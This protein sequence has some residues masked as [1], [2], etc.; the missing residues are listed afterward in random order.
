[1]NRIMV[2]GAG[3]FIGQAVLKLLLTKEDIE[4]HA[5]LNKSDI[6]STLI[7]TKKIKWYKADLTDLVN[8][9]QI[10]GAIRPTSLIHLAWSFNKALD[11]RHSTKN[12]KWIQPSVELY[13]QFIQNGGQRAVFAGT[14]FEYD[15]RF[16]VCQEYL[17]PLDH[18]SL[19]SASKNSIR[20]LI[21][22]LAEQTNNSLAWARIF[23][24]Y[25]PNEIQTRLIPSVIND[26]IQN[27]PVKCS[28]GLQFRDYLYVDDVAGA[29][30]AILESSIT[31]VVNIG[32]GSVVRIKEIVEI[33]AAKY[34]NSTIDFGSLSSP[35]NDPPIIVANV[36]RLIREVG[37]KQIVD[38]QTGLELT[39]QWWLDQIK[40]AS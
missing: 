30:L 39:H 36:G 11:Y 6:P 25:G 38:L 28:N 15:L 4:I 1:M 37:Y 32:S 17:T 19:Y 23:Y 9:A 16:G 18:S 24:V 27:K 5:I 34:S 12:I 21:Q 31:G 14:C 33:L 13:T 40:M 20:N 22:C 2:T 8:I 29:L 10:V 35:P 26:L 7:D 3:G